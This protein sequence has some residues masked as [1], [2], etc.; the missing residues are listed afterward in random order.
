MP[1]KRARTAYLKLMGA[2]DRRAQLSNVVWVFDGVV[3]EL[4][5]S[6]NVEI[7]DVDQT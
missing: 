3:R 4:N 1:H 6:G 2:I 5:N 7:N